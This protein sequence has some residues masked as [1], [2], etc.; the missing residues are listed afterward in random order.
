MSR[1]SPAILPETFDLASILE[2]I[3]SGYEL[4]RSQRRQRLRE[5]REDEEYRQRLEDR[6]RYLRQLRQQELAQPGT[7]TLSAYLTDELARAAREP[8]PQP[9]ESVVSFR[10]RPL[11]TL[12]TDP[13]VVELRRRQAMAEGPLTPET[14]KRVGQADE[15]G[16]EL[17]F[18]TPP[19]TRVEVLGRTF[20]VPGRAPYVTAF[21]NVVD[22]QRA[23]REAT[24]ARALEEYEKRI[25]ALPTPQEL[26]AEAA[27][28]EAIARGQRLGRR[29][30]PEER[31]EDLRYAEELARRTG[32][33]A[34]RT[35]AAARAPVERTPAG[36]AAL[37]RQIEDQRRYIE[38]LNRTIF[39]PLNPNDEVEQEAYRSALTRL[40]DAMAE[41]DALM[42]ERD[43]LARELRGAAPITPDRPRRAEEPNPLR[44]A[45]RYTPGGWFFGSGRTAR[46]AEPQGQQPQGQELQA[47][48][49]SGPVKLRPSDE[50]LKSVMPWV[51]P[52][53]VEAAFGGERIGVSQQDY[54]QIVRT[55]GAEYAA[56][57]FYVKR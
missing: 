34:Q 47:Q 52:G 3:A 33:L 50:T 17:E 1:Y 2:R 29:P 55:M 8:A 31:R 25:A 23:A 12:E 42:A 24:V 4:A 6:N 15:M 45:F 11:K 19:P 13:R 38:T 30:T 43:S 22:P 28:A 18:K 39:P 41:L 53:E 54:D 49:G 56:K 21:G 27:R 26:E 57:N 35:A 20:E 32:L 36:L 37:E 46:P 48:Q 10:G 9:S 51:S 5:Q 14:L 44:D 16:L 40:Q 7:T